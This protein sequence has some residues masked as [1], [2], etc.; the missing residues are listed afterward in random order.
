MSTTS[1][2]ASN[3]AFSPSRRQSHIG[4]RGC[5]PKDLEDGR[6]DGPRRVPFFDCSTCLV[7]EASTEIS[8]LDQLAQLRDPLVIAARFARRPLWPSLTIS[9]FTADR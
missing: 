3:L 2:R 4:R 9:V 5:S 6:C 1:S 8:V 7:P